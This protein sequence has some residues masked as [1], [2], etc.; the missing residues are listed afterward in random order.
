MLTRPEEYPMDIEFGVGLSN[1]LFEMEGQALNE[2]IRGRILQQTSRYMPY[3][4]VTDI[5]FTPDPD[6]NL[7]SIRLVYNISETELPQFFNLDVSL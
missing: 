1:Y 2:Q 7:L 3:I 4:S 6:N 5:S